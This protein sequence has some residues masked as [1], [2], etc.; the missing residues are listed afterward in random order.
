[1]CKYGVL[2]AQN[3]FFLQEEFARLFVGGELVVFCIK[4]K[5]K[6]I[7]NMDISGGSPGK[8][9]KPLLRNFWIRAGIKTG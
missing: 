4:K 6:S 7:V 9:D 5:S 1:L 8:F 2:L 3:D